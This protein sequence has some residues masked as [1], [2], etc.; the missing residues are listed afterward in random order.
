MN[1]FLLF[2]TGTGPK[3]AADVVAVSRIPSVVIVNDNLPRSVVLEVSDNMAQQR[4]R[5]F[6]SWS[7]QAS[8]DIELDTPSSMPKQEMRIL[9]FRLV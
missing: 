5:H 4:L 1:Q 7:L 6:T 8:Q 9:R 3:P 2:Y